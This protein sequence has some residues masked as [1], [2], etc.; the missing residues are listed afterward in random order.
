MLQIS[1]FSEG[2]SVKAG[3]L[4]HYKTSMML[5]A[6]EKL[7]NSIQLMRNEGTKRSVYWKK[8][9]LS[10]YSFIESLYVFL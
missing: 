6:P 3:G 5:I 8:I 7:Q 4:R 9:E 2:D 10:I 1:A